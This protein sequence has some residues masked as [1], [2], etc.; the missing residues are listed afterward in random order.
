MSIW[1]VVAILAF[2]IA[3]LIAF[4]TLSGISVIGLVCVGLAFQAV[5][6]SGLAWGRRGTPNG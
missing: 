6:L 2:A 3:A 5:H 1:I 4:S